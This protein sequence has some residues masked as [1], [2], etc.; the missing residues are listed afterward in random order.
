MFGMRQHW[1]TWN[2]PSFESQLKNI[3]NQ[4][5]LIP[6]HMLVLLRNGRVMDRISYCNWLGHC[7]A[8]CQVVAY[9]YRMTRK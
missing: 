1:K 9:C 5:S 8:E 4:N 7:N 6:P 2:T 3:G